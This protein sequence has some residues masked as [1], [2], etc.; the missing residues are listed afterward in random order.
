MAARL[1]LLLTAM[2]LAAPALAHAGTYNVVTCE[3]GGGLYANLAWA[4]ANAPVGD[5][6]FQTDGSCAGPGDSVGVALA[7]GHAYPAGSA[8]ALR[9][10]APAGTTIADYQLRLVMQ[11]S[12]SPST[13]TDAIVTLG[14]SV[15]LGAG[16]WDPAVQKTLN[17]REGRWL[18]YLGGF[19]GKQVQDVPATKLVLARGASPL[20]L[21]VPAPTSMSLQAGCWALAPG[22]CSLGATANV[23][24][25][26]TGS[27]VT[28]DDPSPP[29]LALSGGAGLLASGARTGGEAVG[30]A[31]SDNTG[32]R[33]AELIDVT[34]P[35]RPVVVGVTPNVCD[36]RRPLPCPD[37]P[38]GT[39][40][41]AKQLVGRHAL[42]VRVTDA[43]GNQT[44]SAPFAILARGPG[45]GMGASDGAR[46]SAGFRTTVVRRVKGK[47]RRV[48]VLRSTAAV[49][50]GG[51]PTVRGTLR[52]AAGRAIAGARLRLTTREARRGAPSV[53]GGTV[54]TRKDGS[55]A[56]DLPAG[57]S[58]TITLSYTPFPGDDRPGASRSLRLTVRAGVSLTAPAR[59]KRG[60]AATFRGRLSGRPVPARTVKLELQ[61]A[62][63]RTA[64]KTVRTATARSDGRFALAVRPPAGR[65]AYRVLVRPGAGYPYAAAASRIARLRVG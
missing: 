35:A 13:T 1:A 14:N 7:P 24:A 20:A 43:A 44:A 57:A 42:L 59:V 11:W 39:V 8:A 18:G 62:V 32:I 61:R 2:A 63:S 49:G 9:F 23:G 34:D 45:N 29:A 46:L 3:N 50:F 64:W 10:Q 17:D 27:T 4:T 15:V 41:A 30:F 38:G 19:G 28:I 55:F 22:G 12:A 26:L 47:R 6:R 37:L 48:R 33:R 58:R 51:D 60:R 5:G 31:A 54:K 16:Q 56:A 25:R 53:A 36:Y 21:A 40:A 52:N 65:P